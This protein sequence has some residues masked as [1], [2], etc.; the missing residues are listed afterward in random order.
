MLLEIALDGAQANP[1]DAGR[2]TLG[3]THLEA[4]KNAFAQID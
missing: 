1:E 4:A 2:L 3:P